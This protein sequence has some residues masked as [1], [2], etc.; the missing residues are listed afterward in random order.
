[1]LYVICP[2]YLPSDNRLNELLTWCRKSQRVQMACKNR[3]CFCDC[4]TEEPSPDTDFFLF[5]YR[6][7]HCC[8]YFTWLSFQLV[9]VMV[10]SLL[11]AWHI[12]PDTHKMLYY[13]C[14][15]FSILKTIAITHW[16]NSTR[17]GLSRC[18]YHEMWMCVCVCVCAHENKCV[19]I[20]VFLYVQERSSSPPSSDLELDFCLTYL[21]IRTD[22]TS[23]SSLISQDTE[24]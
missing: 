4:W 12:L 11:I 13:F 20:S 10:F 3:E 24:L 17:L 15:L 7:F 14:T 21:F 6:P 19:W 18:L 2:Q 9:A 5:K 16:E 22:P 1:M 23:A 8:D